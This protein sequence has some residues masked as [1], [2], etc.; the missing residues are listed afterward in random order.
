MTSEA[1]PRA[2][3]T[4]YHYGKIKENHVP[5]HPYGTTQQT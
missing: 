3:P 2:K 1:Q 5:E 4:Q